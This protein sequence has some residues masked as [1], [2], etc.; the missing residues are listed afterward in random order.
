[1]SQTVSSDKDLQTVFWRRAKK[2]W[3]RLSESRKRVLREA[4]ADS[5][6]DLR[7]ATRRIQTRIDVSSLPQRS[8]SSVKL[9]KRIKR[10][11]HA[12]GGRRDVDVMLDKLRAETRGSA[13]ARRRRVLRSLT[14]SLAPGSKRQ[15]QQVRRKI[16]KIGGGKLRRLCHRSLL[17]RH[18]KEAIDRHSAECDRAGGTQMAIHG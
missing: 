7:V 16:K 15:S 12:A 6:H 11:R 4:D 3:R 9:R 5:I 13:T 14:R 8:K 10:L 2:L 18:S 17:S 1:M